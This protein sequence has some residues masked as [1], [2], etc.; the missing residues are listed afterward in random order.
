M[1]IADRLRDSFEAGESPTDL[2]VEDVVFDGQFPDAI[3]RRSGPAAIT[4]LMRDEAPA[5]TVEQWDVIETSAGGVVI[6]YAYRTVATSSRYSTGVIVATVTAGR[7]SRIL[8]TCAGSWDP[9]TEQRI[10]TA[11]AA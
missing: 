2:Y 5:R 4:A 9:A 3:I 6:E 11:V 10:R 1:T 7:I 8:V